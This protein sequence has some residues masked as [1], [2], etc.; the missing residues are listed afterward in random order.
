[1]P[2]TVN[3]GDCGNPANLANPECKTQRESLEGAIGTDALPTSNECPATIEKYLKAAFPSQFSQACQDKWNNFAKDCSKQ[4]NFLSDRCK[5][6]R[7]QLEAGLAERA[8]IEA[9]AKRQGSLTQL[10]S[11]TRSA[12][13]KLPAAPKV[14][15]NCPK[16]VEAFAAANKQSLNADCINIWTKFLNDLKRIREIQQK[17]RVNASN[18][19]YTKYY[20]NLTIKEYYQGVNRNEA[21][22]ASRRGQCVIRYSYHP[23][24]KIFSSRKGVEIKPNTTK[25][26]CEMEYRFLIQKKKEQD[27]NTWRID[28]NHHAFEK[29]WVPDRS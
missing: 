9:A 4:E 19:L 8:A 17:G 2:G 28:M 5:T 25:E 16:T 20:S 1:V 10:R 24:G 27:D 7:A 3:P 22:L 23:N 15:N 21:Y 13:A 26:Q 6:Q 12:G 11:L 29:D 18:S 14:P